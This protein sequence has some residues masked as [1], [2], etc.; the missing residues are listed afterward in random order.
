MQHIIVTNNQLVAEKY[1]NVSWQSSLAEI[2]IQV[3]DRIH[4]GHELVSH[5]L[6]ASLRMIYS[7]YKSIIVSGEP[8]DINHEHT[9][10]IENS[11]AEYEKRMKTR[12]ADAVNGEDYKKMDL[13]LL[14]SVLDDIK[15]K[16]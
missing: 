6:P 13:L 4:Q 7:P 11:I 15:G 3:R 8:G 14:E 1:E 12:K 2:L 10:I 5:P 16:W 9:Q